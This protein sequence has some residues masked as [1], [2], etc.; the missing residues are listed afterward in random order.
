MSV[1][2]RPEGSWCIHIDH[3]NAVRSNPSVPAW[4]NNRLVSS[5]AVMRIRVKYR[6][7]DM[8]SSMLAPGRGDGSSGIAALASRIPGLISRVALLLFQRFNTCVSYS[9]G[10]GSPIWADVCTLNPPTP[11]HPKESTKGVQQLPRAKLT[12]VPP[13]VGSVQPSSCELCQYRF[14]VR[15]HSPCSSIACRMKGKTLAIWST[16]ASATS[17]CSFWVSGAQR[18]WQ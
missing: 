3:F 13:L 11:T 8:Y 4:A 10:K 12:R 1:A 14:L 15:C 9:P 7:Y 2:I 5:S 6:R 16:H 18:T 17:R